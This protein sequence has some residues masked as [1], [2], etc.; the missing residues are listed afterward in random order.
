[1]QRKCLAGLIIIISSWESC[2]IL[3]SM[4]S[5]FL[6][7]VQFLLVFL[8]IPKPSSFAGKFIFR[9]VLLPYFPTQF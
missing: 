9:L 5:F 4:F 1:M 7:L 2:L 8:L 3:S 6:R